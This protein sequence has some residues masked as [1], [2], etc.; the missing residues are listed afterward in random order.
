MECCFVL[1]CVVVVT[2]HFISFYLSLSLFHSQGFISKLFFSICLE[3]KKCWWLPSY[4]FRE[5][6][7][8]RERKYRFIYA[9]ATI[10]CYHFFFFCLRLQ[11]GASPLLSSFWMNDGGGGLRNLFFSNGQDKKKVLLNI[12]LSFHSYHSIL[13]KLYVCSA[14]STHLASSKNTLCVS[15]L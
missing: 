6:N 10:F 11:L 9:L 12:F 15:M 5:R 4:V 7:K 14:C 8:M 13:A 3:N 2:F 1:F